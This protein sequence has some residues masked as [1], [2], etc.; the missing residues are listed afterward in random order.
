ML[1]SNMVATGMTVDKVEDIYQT[2]IDEKGLK[3]AMFSAGEAKP[4]PT[5]THII[6]SDGMA[7]L[8][9]QPVEQIQKPAEQKPDA[10]VEEQ[11]K[12][13]SF[14]DIINGDKPEEKPATIETPI[15]EEQPLITEQVDYLQNIPVDIQNK[16]VAPYLARIEELENKIIAD[17]E[18][19]KDKLAFLAKYSPDDFKL[20]PEFY[21]KEKLSEE[22]GAD[23]K[24]DANEALIYNTPSYKYVARQ[25]ELLDEATKYQDMAKNSISEK[26]Q[27]VQELLNTARQTVKQKYGVA[28]EDFNRID[29][30]L[31]EMNSQDAYEIVF[32]GI[33]AQE[34][35][36]RKTA[37]LKA[38]NERS[39]IP[40]SVQD[41]GTDRAAVASADD[42][43]LEGI[44]GNAWRQGVASGKIKLQGVSN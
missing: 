32:K 20:Q 16:I 2:P 29:K 14:T 13:L 8:K 30:M 26:D 25:R 15:Q 4:D 22:F 34:E 31:S 19:T 36:A 5:A 38:A 37:G 18:Y 41:I 12:K 21:L 24:P 28:D 43:A 6:T 17:E 3:E 44:F 1:E 33:L 40:P 11:T 42:I 10:N 7:E 39:K 23:F 27:R 9:H 35:L